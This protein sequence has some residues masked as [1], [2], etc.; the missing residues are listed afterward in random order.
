M[1]TEKARALARAVDTGVEALGD[2]ELLALLLSDGRRG[3][4]SS[5]LSA[6]L[7]DEHG[8]VAGLARAGLG[9]LSAWGALGEAKAS[10]VAAAVELGRRALAEDAPR[11]VHDAA[12]VWR[13]ARGRLAALEHEELWVLALDGANR[14]RAA[15]RVAMGG[16]HGMHVGTRD[17]LRCA[18][19]EGAS[20][21]VLVHNHPSGDATPSPEDVAFTTRVSE[22]G[23]L[24]GAPLVDHVVVTRGGYVSLAEQSL[25]PPPPSARRGDSG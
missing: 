8:G 24:V 25:I 17:P 21:F 18:L 23:D 2:T 13:W 1:A 4:G 3:P 6:A 10:R 22:G 19:R 15:R 11:R 9:A 16:L 7:L 20:A 12:D 5:A 14:L